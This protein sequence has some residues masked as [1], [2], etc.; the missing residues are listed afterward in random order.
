MVIGVTLLTFALMALFLGLRANTPSDGARIAAHRD[1]WRDDGVIITPYEEAGDS[2]LRPGDKVI[3]VNGILMSNLAQSAVVGPSTTL[4][5]DYQFGQSVTYTIERNGREMDV[6]VTLGHFPFAGWLR[7]AW[8]SIVVTFL[9]MVITTIVVLRRTDRTTRAMAL[10]VPA[11]WAGGAFYLLGLQ[12]G[13]FVFPANLWLFMFVATAGYVLVLVA[14]VRFAFE[15]TRPPERVYGVVRSGK[16]IVLT[17]LVPYGFLAAYLVL[18]WFILRNALRWFGSWRTGTAIIALISFVLALLIA[19][20]SYAQTRD[21]DTRKKIRWIV[22]AGGMVGVVNLLLNVLPS[23]IVRQPI[24]GP[25]LNTIALF[26][27]Q[28]AIAFAILRYRYLEVD[29]II[30]RTLVAGLITI[31]VALFYFGGLI[32]VNTILDPSGSQQGSDIVIVVTTLIAI[33]LFDR[34]RRTAQHVVDRIF[35]RNKYRAEKTLAQFSVALRDDAY[36]DMN[37]LTN[38]LLAVTRDMVQ[39]AQVGL[40]LRG[41]SRDGRS[42]ETAIQG[43]S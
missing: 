19:L 12:V 8:L 6:P 1:V 14:V 34:I 24:I 27:F 36:A 17:Y 7:E 21:Y 23:L 33:A 13:D 18:M 29:F 10:W 39:P 26:I 20:W 5:E 43:R 37:L 22:Y 42:N 16:T 41:N 2:G 31:V 4:G 38:D 40:W 25:T 3:A 28:L 30:N 32:F 11:M 15:F 35:Y 9:G